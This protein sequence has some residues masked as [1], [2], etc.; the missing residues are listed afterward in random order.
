MNGIEARLRDA[1]LRPTRQRMGLA[2]LLFGGPCRHVSAEE[3]FAEAA[4]SGVKV[5]LATVYNTLNQ[6]VAAG[7]L[8]EV[9]AE[10]GR[11]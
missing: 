5:S 7:L 10:P 11:A 2:S 6:F 9:L 3:L 4:A 1:G 8:R